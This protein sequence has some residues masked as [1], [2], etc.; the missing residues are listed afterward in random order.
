MKAIKPQ[1]LSVFYRTFEAAGRVEL[2]VTVLLAAPFDAPESP[3]H[4]ANLWKLLA[5]ELGPDTPPDAGM[6]KPRAEVLVIGQAYPQG[7]ERPL[8]LSLG[9]IDKA[10]RVSGKATGFGPLDAMAPERVARAGTYD[11]AWLE[12]RSPDLPL[13]F[14]PA[15]HNTAPADQ[16]LDEPF[17]GGEPFTLEH[18]HPDQP[19][20]TGRL[21]RLRPRAFVKLREG[22]LRE[23]PM[24]F[25]TVQLFPAAERML[26]LFR[27]VTPVAEDDA[28]DVLQLIAACEAPG[29]PR[30]LAHYQAVL[31]ERLDRKRGA[32]AALRDGDLMPPGPAAE[33]ALDELTDPDLAVQSEQLKARNM[34]R[35]TARQRDEVRARIQAAGLDP[36]EHLPLAPPAEPGPSATAPTL[37][38]IEGILAR[39]QKDAARRKAEAAEERLATEAE[40]R[41][42]AQAA[43]IDYDKALLEQ[44]KQQG[45]PPKFSA[46]AENE[47]LRDMLQLAQNA[48]TPL[49]AVEARLADP[50]LREKLQ[51]VEEQLREQYRAAAHR[52]PAAPPAAA[53]VSERARVE[54][55][56]GAQGGVSFAGRDLTGADLAGLDLRGVDLGSAFLE[57]ASLAG[58]NLSG[59]NLS[60]AVLARADLTR[61][62]LTGARLAGC[63]LGQASLTDADLAGA[64]LTRAVLAGADLTRA[65]FRGARLHGVDLEEAIF[66]DTDFGGVAATSLTFLRS[67]LRGIKLAGASLVKCSFI[68]VDLR[69]ADLT[70]AD[71]SAATFVTADA[72]GA[73][74]R[75]ATLT[76]LRAVQGSSFE[77]ADFTGAALEGANLRGMNLAGCSFARARLG[78]ADLSGCDLRGA[79]FDRAIAH[80]ARFTKADL[81]GARL[82]DANL[83][84]ALVDRANVRGASFRGANLFRADLSK[85]EADDATV[86]DEANLTRARVTRRARAA[87]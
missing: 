9:P 85:I 47:R 84:L 22:E 63:N 79:R 75:G 41:R 76:R 17:A 70:G 34:R 11:D 87:S 29:S 27:G 56:S 66:D 23:V 57:G 72:A 68:E 18:M 52:L 45:G 49:P 54:L 61:A 5:A 60:R 16:Q 69:G 20:L 78:G 8:R 64:D 12:E 65:R 73:R 74:L 28:S 81:S 14:D 31:A 42:R 33:V 40:A 30:P 1:K 80:E 44:K 4:E 6:P 36:D 39:A 15:Y 37:D 71:L 13:D 59:A 53:S 50:R 55:P 38:E 2:C 24:R 83:M 51:A 35:K 82:V 62:D 48:G 86:L 43:G 7:E 32:L 21:P 46:E 10:M 67:E 25:E 19:V 77:G 26:L 3:L 58:A